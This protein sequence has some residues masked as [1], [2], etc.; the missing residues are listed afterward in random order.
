MA[1]E[2]D[3]GIRK[4][5]F[6]DLIIGPNGSHGRI[7]EVAG[8]PNG[9]VKVPISPG[10]EARQVPFIYQKRIAQAAGKPSLNDV[11]LLDTATYRQIDQLWSASRS[12]ENRWLFRFARE[13]WAQNQLSQ[14]L[15]EAGVPVDQLR[16]PRVHQAGF[17]TDFAG[18]PVPYIM[19][20]KVE[21]MELERL[22]RLGSQSERVSFLRNIVSEFTAL[23]IQLDIANH[24]DGPQIIHADINSRN[25]M[26]GERISLIDFGQVRE[27]D[28]FFPASNMA[29]GTMAFS[30]WEVLA[31]EPVD[32]ATDQAGMMTT[33]IWT[34][35][36]SVWGEEDELLRLFRRNSTYVNDILR[37]NDI[38]LIRQQLIKLK[39]EGSF[40]IDTYQLT[41]LLSEYGFDA[42]DPEVEAIC[43]IAKRATHMNASDRYGQIAAPF[44]QMCA[45]FGVPIPDIFR[46]E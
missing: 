21:G 14:R 42:S 16:V 4:P 1:L 26:L 5:V 25:M 39:T 35:G 11:D 38:N 3:S 20:D 19:M 37:T 2:F 8:I 13:A 33:L 28:G 17:M 46:S 27:S 43:E 31:N 34:L 15:L 10:G 41:Q 12:P 9:V 24:W 18:I 29:T 23:A 36:R 32:Q 22:P 30:P 7:H 45:H 44:M 6:A 40:D